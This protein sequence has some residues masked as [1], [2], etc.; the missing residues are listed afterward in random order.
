MDALQLIDITGVVA[1]IGMF[2]H[3]L[4]FKQRAIV[5]FRE[6]S[7]QRVTVFFREL[8]ICYVSKLF[9]R[10]AGV[11]IASEGGIITG[12]EISGRIAA[13]YGTLGIASETASAGVGNLTAAWVAFYILVALAAA[14]IIYAVYKDRRI[15]RDIG[16]F[17][18]LLLEAYAIFGVVGFITSF[19]LF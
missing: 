9:G 5:F 18:K 14:E 12:A 11:A 19:V 3:W 17:G 7:F 4:L 6:M 8:G 1:G 16:K 10:A 15:L 2:T 13:R